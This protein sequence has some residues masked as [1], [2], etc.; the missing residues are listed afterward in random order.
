MSRQLCAVMGTVLGHKP[1]SV[2]TPIIN[3]GKPEVTGRMLATLHR[4]LQLE[5]PA[6]SGTALGARRGN[7]ARPLL[8][9]DG[10]AATNDHRAGNA[11]L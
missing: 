4:R 1:Q 9:S 10:P 7:R 6:I 11:H 2:Q 5:P 8:P 3:F